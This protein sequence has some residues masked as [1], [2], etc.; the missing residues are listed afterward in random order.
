L[1]LELTQLLLALSL[2]VNPVTV[3]AGDFHDVEMQSG[4][5][6]E[7]ALDNPSAQH[8]ESQDPAQLQNP[9]CDK[10]CCEDAGCFE[11]GVCFIQYTP[12]VVTLTNL[13]FDLSTKSRDWGALSTTV[14]DRE[15]P[16]DHPPPIFL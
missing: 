11:Q 6:I 8:E 5:T 2:V 4:H 15:L 13:E 14:P 3:L 10:S 12:G 7:E 16:P 9:D 1:K